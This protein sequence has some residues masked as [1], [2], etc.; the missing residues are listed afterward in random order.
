MRVVIATSYFDDHAHGMLLDRGVEI[1][2]I[3]HTDTP[4]AQEALLAEFDPHGL[5]S[6]S[7]PVTASAIDAAPS[8]RAIART[9]TGYDNVNVAAATRRGIPVLFSHGGSSLTVAEHALGLIF[10]L[11]RNIAWY[12]AHVRSGGWDRFMFQGQELTGKRLGIVGY[13]ES[14]KHMV[15]IAKGVGMN[16]SVYAPRYRYGAPPSDVT[17]AE[18]LHG[19]LADAEIVSLHCPLTDATRGMIDARAI[20]AMR[21]GAW[22]VNTAR[23][24]VIDE[25]AL[26]EG[27]ISGQI[28]GAA[29]DTFEQE[30]P[31]PDHPFFSMRN[32]VLTPHMAGASVQAAR[33]A[34][35]MAASNL[36]AALDG[37]PVDTRA[38]ANPEVLSA[39]VA[40]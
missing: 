2:R 23:G 38:M 40:G 16:L 25:P 19:L 14:G 21:P 30:P 36:L 11:A 15:R 7:I 3:D 29:L 33:R 8:L 4:Q 34:H 37:R 13:G 22:I 6:R 12:D 32:V 39:S 27:L 20:E 5:I 10:A 24:A 17:V 18:S 9:G 31:R 1:R 28:G 26:I 35:T